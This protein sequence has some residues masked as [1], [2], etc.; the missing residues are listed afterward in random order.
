MRGQQCLIATL[1]GLC[2]YTILHLY[3]VSQFQ[4]EPQVLLDPLRG[5]DFLFTQND[6][7][8]FRA[9]VETDRARYRPG[10]TVFL[11]TWFTYYQN[12]SQV[13]PFD[14][15][16]ESS[17]CDW[18][19]CS[20]GN[21]AIYDG[22]GNSVFNANNDLNIFNSTIGFSYSVPTDAPGGQYVACVSH[23]EIIE[24]CR[25]FKVLL[26][27]E[28]LIGAEVKWNQTSYELGSVAFVE[29]TAHNFKTASS[30]RNAPFRASFSTAGVTFEE[31][32]GRF[33]QHG[34]AY[35]SVQLPT[36][37]A[38]VQLTIM[39]TYEGIRESKSFKVPIAI[40]Q[41]EILF[42]TQPGWLVSDMLNTIAFESFIKGTA[43]PAQ[44]TGHINGVN[45]TSED[46]GRGAFILAPRLGGNYSVALDNGQII[47]IPLEVKL[48]GVLIDV[49]RHSLK[50]GETLIVRFLSRA[51]SKLNY[52]VNNALVFS[53]KENYM[54]VD[55]TSIPQLYAGGVLRIVGEDNGVENSEVLVLVLPSE[56]LKVQIET[57]QSEFEP[58]D[59]VTCTVTVTT[60]SGKPVAGAAVALTATSASQKPNWQLAEVLLIEDEVSSK[61]NTLTAAAFRNPLVGRGEYLKDFIRNGSCDA[62]CQRRLNLLMM[63]QDWRRLAFNLDNFWERLNTLGTEQG[64]KLKKLIGY[65]EQIYYY[66]SNATASPPV[67]MPLAGAIREKTVKEKAQNGETEFIPGDSSS[68]GDSKGA[69]Q[70]MHSRRTDWV[71]GEQLDFTQTVAWTSSHMTGID[72]KF[73]YVFDLNDE[74]SGLTLSAQALSPK[75]LLGASEHQLA[76]TLPL[77]FTVQ[78]PMFVLQGDKLKAAVTV[79]N[80]YPLPM[81]VQVSVSDTA[82]VE[83][84]LSPNSYST[85]YLD[86]P[87]LLDTDVIF[88]LIAE[89]GVKRVNMIK[90]LPLRV[91]NP[92][93]FHKTHFSGVLGKDDIVYNYTAPESH[94]SIQV[95]CQVF[96]STRGTLTAA[97]ESFLQEPCG[98]F[99]QT[100]STTFPTTM[101]LQYFNSH[102]DE[103]T[104][105]L[106]EKTNDLLKTG[107]TRLLTFETQTGGFEWFGESPGHEAL[108]A[109]GL[110][111]FREMQ[112]AGF[113]ELD[114]EV[115]TRTQAWLLSRRT[116]SGSFQ[117]SSKQIDTF[118]YAP[119]NISDAYIVWALSEG[120]E[121][122]LNSSLEYLFGL[123]KHTEDPYFL[124]LTALS[125]LN[126]QYKTESA[127]DYLARLQAHQQTDGTVTGAATSVTS[128]RFS[129]LEIETT[130]LS[131]LAW[132]K[133]GGFQT[134]VEMG[135]ESILKRC[136]AGGFGGTQ[137]TILAL[138]AIVEYDKIKPTLPLGGEIQLFSDKFI[139]ASTK[140]EDPK[141]SVVQLSSKQPTLTSLTIKW[142]DAEEQSK[143]FACEVS[144]STPQPPAFSFPLPIN[145]EVSL[146]SES[147]TIGQPVTLSAIVSNT[148][149]EASGMTVARLGIPSCTRLQTE[150]LDTLVQNQQ[151]ASYEL[152]DGGELVLYWKGLEAEGIKRVDLN[153]ICETVGQ[154]K[155][156][157]SS[158]YLYYGSEAKDWVSSLIATVI[159]AQ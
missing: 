48:K 131:V 67:F 106:I 52:Y 122:D 103:D 28:P 115:T 68:F 124:A 30:L 126:S 2:F 91:F 32:T 13:T 58:A 85:Q 132:L 50:F 113:Y 19:A 69:R 76:S 79:K 149:T 130:A 18:A 1:A 23:S 136:K 120:G 158:A 125:F 117:Q 3:V 78:M 118:G 56:A 129:D 42:H 127:I 62:V 123:A 147:C 11:R 70:F 88:K 145:I 27:A 154:C 36:L 46:F 44:V 5:E 47:P 134:Q 86:I 14:C 34:L 141:L 99:E 107:Y 144:T 26:Q 108:T 157:S 142:F 97:L 15:E 4:D 80:S 72:G 81:N 54:E 63:S 71:A 33:D 8:R 66:E 82:H 87:S 41:I 20:S 153:L 75:G 102:I 109:Y 89:S 74:A 7:I 101:A 61:N 12:H 51:K 105:S 83:F 152:R 16:C 73:T 40:Q 49:E 150:E 155:G 39:L 53:Q 137:A 151:L 139:V 22:Q 135:V 114:W 60:Q 64:N 57:G 37:P 90:K 138:K 59:S 121:V 119:A 31:Q 148:E 156:K 112:N 98:C 92:N 45:F 17:L 29:V 9:H 65:Q 77:D 35:L 111:Q 55:T 6:P 38:E 96:M 21:V 133:A 95:D 93:F 25:E 104:Y 110:L 10:D 94:S 116:E 43:E 140:L 100:S 159:E 128:S 143:P 146:S 24:A 84:D